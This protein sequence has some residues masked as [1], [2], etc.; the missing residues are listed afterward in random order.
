MLLHITCFSLTMVLCSS[1][2]TNGQK[3]LEILGK[4]FVFPDIQNS[5]ETTVNVEAW[6][7]RGIWGN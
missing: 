7:W 1:G 2:R 3:E 5:Y 6:Y 4:R